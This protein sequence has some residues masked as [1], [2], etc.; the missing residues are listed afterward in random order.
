MRAGSGCWPGVDME[1]GSKYWNGA[2]MC[3]IP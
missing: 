2:D 1:V 3:V